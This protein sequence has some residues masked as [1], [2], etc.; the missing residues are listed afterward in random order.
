MVLFAK[1]SRWFSGLSLLA[2]LSVAACDEESGGE[3][4]P[5]E[6]TPALC[7]DGTDNDGDGAVDCADAECAPME[8]CAFSL[9]PSDPDS[10]GMPIPPVDNVPRPA[11]APGNLFVLDWAGFK[12]ALTYSFDDTHPSHLEH[13]D[14]LQ[15]TG[16]KVTFFAVNETATDIEGWRRAVADGHEIGNHTAHH[17][18]AGL[19]GECAFGT[20]LSSADE[21][22]A[23]CSDYIVDNFGQPG[24]WT[25]ASPY[26]EFWWSL[27]AGDYVLLNR[28]VTSGTIAPNEELDP[29]K[30][31]AIMLPGGAGAAMRH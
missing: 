22:I 14:A 23:A 18:H 29:L 12:A 8:S 30:L 20:P 15:T 2:A 10:S 26:G 17:C 4:A 6:N 28:S 11:G 3:P 1:R 27:Y 21:E 7:G 25:M 9:P 16:V 5:R 19:T 31:P 13:Y 24:V